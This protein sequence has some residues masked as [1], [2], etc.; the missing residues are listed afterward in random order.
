MW[1]SRPPKTANNNSA[2]DCNMKTSGK[3]VVRD[4]TGPVWERVVFAEVLVPNVANVYSD[5]WTEIAVR[6]AAYEFM[7][8][9]FGIDV[10]HDNVDISGYN[11]AR[12]V[13]S[14]IA[15]EG[16]PDFIK[17]A[18]VVGLYIADDA[19]WEQVL[20]GEINGFSYEAGVLMQPATLEIL[21]DG[22]RTGITEPSIE[23]GHTHDFMV[24]VGADNRP[25]SGG[26][27]Y[28]VDHHHD[29]KRHT[30]TEEANGHVHRYNLVSGA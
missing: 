3:L 21:D 24:M 22:I 9:G 7:K 15:R 17:G 8:Q 1:V 30:V 4:D 10:E 2:I 11:G 23:D 6:D 12:V 29:I 20:S 13:E 27:S 19:L 25:K 16:D 18:W 26:T 5:Y 28:T 14:F